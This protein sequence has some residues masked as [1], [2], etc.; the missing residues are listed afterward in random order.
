M[1]SIDL[2]LSLPLVKGTIQY[3]HILLQPLMIDTKAYFE[4][5][6]SLTGVILAYVSSIESYTFIWYFSGDS[7]CNSLG[8]SL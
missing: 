2:D 4:F 8:R 7:S 3:E 5:S 6:F 1:D